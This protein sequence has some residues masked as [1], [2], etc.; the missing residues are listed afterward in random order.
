MA[1]SATIRTFERL[2]IGLDLGEGEMKKGSNYGPGD[3]FYVSCAI[4][5]KILQ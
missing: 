4:H 5:G 1:K 3:L 2:L